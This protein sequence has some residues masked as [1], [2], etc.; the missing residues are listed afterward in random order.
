MQRIGLLIVGLL[1]LGGKPAGGQQA[2]GTTLWRVAA[3]TLATPPALALGPAA[4]IWNPAQT[5]D[6]ARVW[7]AIEAIQTPAAV[8]ATGLIAT[9]RVPAGS[10]GQFGL[11]FGRV[12]LSDVTQTVDSPDPTGSSVPVYTFAV[13]TT[14]SRLVG[15][16]SVGATL[17]FHDTRLD[18]ATARRWT[19]D[20]GASRPFVGDRFRVAAA[21]HF[22]SSLKTNDPAQDVFAGIEGRFWSGAMSGNRVVLRARYGIAFAHGFRADHQFGA[23]AEFGKSVTL[24][25]MLAREG[26]YS[27]GSHWRPVG[28]LRV[29]IGKYRVTLARDAGVNDLGSAYRVGVDMRFR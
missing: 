14:W 29:A 13:G 2:T 6:S 28:G 18:V 10:L 24:D 27:D 1:T 19:I 21:T 7:L 15:R 26:G 3:T 17:A 25:L 4:A 16:T 8:D 22:F 9:A 12:G 5:E 23:G 11:L 20:V